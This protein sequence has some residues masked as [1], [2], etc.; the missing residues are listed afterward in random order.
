[1]K[2]AP[3]IGLVVR[4]PSNVYSR[5]ERK[6]SVSGGGR[7]VGVSGGGRVVGVSGGGRVVSVSREAPCE[8]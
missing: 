7:V 5:G 3:L 1:M 4:L 2:M 8:W 6:V